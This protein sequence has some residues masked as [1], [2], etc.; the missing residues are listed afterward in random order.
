[1]KWHQKILTLA[2]GSALLSGLTACDLWVPQST[3]T[4]G[5]TSDGVSARLGDVYI[6]NAVLIAEGTR[7]NLVVSIV[8]ESERRTTV[9]VEYGE[10]QLQRTVQTERAG[11]TQL[12]RRGGQLVIV[13]DFS[14]QPGSLYR[15]RFVHEDWDVYLRVPVLT[16]A[17]PT[18]RE[19]GPESVAPA[20]DT[21]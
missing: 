10:E 17:Q 3:L 15:L 1:M 18:Y 4:N 7:A 2:L 5:E 19:L 12:G 16:D 21:P 8:N 11:I 20:G 6:A 9:T 14:A 13:D